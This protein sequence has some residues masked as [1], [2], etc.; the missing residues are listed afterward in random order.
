[1]LQEQRIW[2]LISLKLSGEATPQELGELEMLTLNDVALQQQIALAVKIWHEKTEDCFEMKEESFDRHLQRLNSDEFSSQDLATPLPAAAS[3]TSVQPAKT[4]SRIH[5]FIRWGSVAA[6]SVL[7]GWLL[8]VIVSNNSGGVASGNT[9][10]TRPGSKSNI[11]LPDGSKVWLN[12]DSKV[13]YTGDAGSNIREV[14]LS[15]EAFFDVVKD[16]NRPFM[17]HTATVDIKVLGTS[18]NVKSYRND[19]ETETSLVQGS[20][21]VTIRNDPDKKIILKPNEKLSVKNDIT[22]KL[23]PL[24]ILGRLRYADKD[25]S[26]LETSWIKNRLVFDAERLDQI[27]PKLERWYNVHIAVTGSSKEAD[28][29]YTGSFE[30]ETLEEVMEAL[31]LTGGFQYTIRK[32]EVQVRR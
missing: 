27:I 20:V 29:R 12:A 5:S 10:Y 2:Q 8:T 30:D 31:R 6:A 25:S 19:K 23:E 21:E 16:K 15:G 17:I 14:F 13:T 4:T 11:T 3:V 24:I 18:F 22:N 26:I 1:M 9:V 7:T 28:P 32:R